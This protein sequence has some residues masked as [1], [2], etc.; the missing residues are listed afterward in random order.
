MD[1]NVALDIVLRHMDDLIERLG[2][3]RVGLG[4]DFDGALV[5]RP[6][7]DCAGLPRLLAAMADHGVDDALMARITHDNW[8]RI[9]RATW[10]Q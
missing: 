7:K 1:D 3:S 10:G 8:L 9:L 6:I 5:P 4:S 2:E